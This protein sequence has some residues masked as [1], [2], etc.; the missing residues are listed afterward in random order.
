MKAEEGEQL[1][2]RSAQLTV[3]TQT[4]L[5]LKRRAKPLMQH[6]HQRHSLPHQAMAEA[7]RRQ[8]RILVP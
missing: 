1:H 2:R 8:A 7:S 3:T 6:H 5:L 4:Q